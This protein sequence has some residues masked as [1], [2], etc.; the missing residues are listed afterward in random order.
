MP[1]MVVTPH[2]ELYCWYGEASPHLPLSSA[3]V[4]VTHLAL[5]SRSHSRPT[6]PRGRC[7]CYDRR[8]VQA[9]SIRHR[10]EKGPS[11]NDLQDKCEQL[12]MITHQLQCSLKKAVHHI[13]I[14]HKFSNDRTYLFNVQVIPTYLLSDQN[15]ESVY[16]FIRVFGKHIAGFLGVF[17]LLHIICRR[18]FVGEM[19]G[20]IELGI[21][22]NQL[23]MM[24]LVAAWSSRSKAGHRI[25]NS[26]LQDGSDLRKNKYSFAPEENTQSRPA[27]HQ[28]KAIKIAFNPIKA[29]TGRQMPL[30]VEHVIGNA[31]EFPMFADTNHVGHPAASQGGRLG[32]S[33]PT[34]AKRAQSPAG[35]PDFR[36][37]ESC[38][39][40]SRAF[41]GISHF[42][43]TFIP[44]PLHTHLNHSHRLSRPP[45][46][47]IR[48]GMACDVSRGGVALSCWLHRRAVAG[49]ARDEK[50]G[51]GGSFSIPA[52]QSPAEA[53]RAITI[54]GGRGPSGAHYYKLMTNWPSGG[55]VSSAQQSANS[56]TQLAAASFVEINTY[57]AIV[58]PGKLRVLEDE[59]AHIRNPHRDLQ[60][61]FREHEDEMKY[62]LWL[63][64]VSLSASASSQSIWPCLRQTQAPMFIPPPPRR[65]LV[66]FAASDSPLTIQEVKT[67]GHTMTPCAFADARDQCTSFT[68]SSPIHAI[69][70]PD[71]LVSPDRPMHHDVRAKPQ[72]YCWKDNDPSLGFILQTLHSLDFKVIDLKAYPGDGVSSNAS[73]KSKIYNLVLFSH[74]W[75]LW[76][77]HR[78]QHEGVF[79]T[80]RFSCG[81]CGKLPWC[82]DF[83]GA[84]PFPTLSSFRYDFT[85]PPPHTSSHPIQSSGW[86]ERQVRPLVHRFD[87][88]IARL[89]RRSDEALGVRVLVSSVWLTRF[90]TLDAQLHNTLN[91]EVLRV[92]EGELSAE[93]AGAGLG[94]DAVGTAV[95]GSP[96]EVDGAVDVIP[97]VVDNCTAGTTPEEI[98][99]TAPTSGIEEPATFCSILYSSCL[100]ELRRDSPIEVRG[101]RLGSTAGPLRFEFWTR[102]DYDNS[103][104]WRCA[105]VRPGAARPTLANQ[106]RS[107]H[108]GLCARRPW[109]RE[110]ELIILINNSRKTRS[111]ANSCVRYS[112]RRSLQRCRYSHRRH[113]QLFPTRARTS[114][115][116]P[117]PSGENDSVK[118]SKLLTP[119][120]TTLCKTSSRRPEQGRNKRAGEAGEPREN[121][122]TIGIFRHDSR[123]RPC[124]ESNPVRIG[125]RRPPLAAMQSCSRMSYWR[126]KFHANSTCCEDWWRFVV[127][128]TDRT[129]RRP[130]MSHI[131]S[132]GDRSGGHVG[133]LL[134]GCCSLDRDARSWPCMSLPYTL[135]L[136]PLSWSTPHSLTTVTGAKF[137]TPS[138]A[139]CTGRGVRGSLA[140]GNLDRSPASSKRLAMILSDTLGATGAL[141]CAAVAVRSAMAARLM[142]R[143]GRDSVCRCLPEPG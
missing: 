7:T 140:S 139:R 49:A 74:F 95:G 118:G 46:E 138:K 42:P 114:S 5:Q 85:P 137:A 71:R 133:H 17:C 40:M 27:L 115:W 62:L 80:E 21:D 92:E 56:P 39:T 120:P 100:H 33:P 35:S 102:V 134:S 36:M 30:F 141:I 48:R 76:F 61:R 110:E 78:S 132:M 51:R 12:T 31:W 68:A 103:L 57:K 43:H 135:W 45:G 84:L 37:W 63:N 10:G 32:C 67:S 69:V 108:V 112:H 65:L 25:R 142:R 127:R 125:G 3:S 130:I 93:T 105:A 104:W 41:S 22:D 90:L 44:A 11:V 131:S 89:A 101:C 117:R 99:R 70:H 52:L 73:L 16:K 129:K 15:S 113:R 6:G 83:F 87:G 54:V 47:E 4:A 97:E 72:N 19:C 119:S 124:R 64:P 13:I 58:I 88:N 94:R 96:E 91:S 2:I 66:R 121:P 20:N 123:E 109:A 128:I 126:I 34:K 18:K 82:E 106:A 98:D 50:S 136:L 53:S 14:F 24:Q 8:R 107:A 81:E 23:A 55:T 38:R 79:Q 26:S 1:W 28:A 60:E 75:R 86:L 59:N 77:D 9:T 143:S 116:R 111:P 122:P 29:H